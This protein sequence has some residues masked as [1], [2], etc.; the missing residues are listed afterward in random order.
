MAVIQQVSHGEELGQ[1]TS[2]AEF[3]GVRP[4]N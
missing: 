1:E 2:V 4:N 3:V